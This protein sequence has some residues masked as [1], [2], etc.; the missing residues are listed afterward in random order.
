MSPFSWA[1][2]HHPPAMHR[3]RRPSNLPVFVFLSLHA[4]LFFVHLSLSSPLYLVSKLVEIRSLLHLPPVAVSVVAAVAAARQ[5]SQSVAVGP[6]CQ[7][8]EVVALS[9]AEV[10]VS[11]RFFLVSE[12]VAVVVVVVRVAF[13]TAPPSLFATSSVRPGLLFFSAAVVAAMLDSLVPLVLSSVASAFVTP[14]PFARLPFRRCLS[15]TA[16]GGTARVPDSS[17]YAVKTT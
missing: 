14:S 15:A 10:V 8:Q 16:T 1:G 7:V 5:A 13:V 4:F 17:P 9:L 11:G 12:T 2:F 6:I 3:R